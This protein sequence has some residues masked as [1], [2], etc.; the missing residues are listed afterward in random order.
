M[1]MLCV[2]NM[3]IDLY[4]YYTNHLWQDEDLVSDEAG[5]DQ[6]SMVYSLTLVL[7]LP[8]PL[9][10]HPPFPSLLLPPP[11]L[12]IVIKPSS[13]RPVRLVNW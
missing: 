12:V 10:W 8:H 3:F 5:V 7:H 6:G 9:W 11:A 2:L 4:T 1:Y 13:T